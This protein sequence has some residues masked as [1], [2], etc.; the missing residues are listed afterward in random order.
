MGMKNTVT[1]KIVLWVGLI[2]VVVLA[3]LF[4]LGTTTCYRSPVCDKIADS[5][6]NNDNLK[7]IFLAPPIFLLSLITYKMRDEVFRAWWNFARW[8]V[9]VIIL[10]TYL[11]STQNG[12]GGMGIGGAMSSAFD[13]II[14]GFFYVVLVIVSLW[15]IVRKYRQL[16]R[17]GK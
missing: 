17:E 8:W 2:G 11:Q 9:P 3:L 5:I 1:K 15:R 7:I 6:P 4:S 13:A 12:G 14:L 10:V 16:K